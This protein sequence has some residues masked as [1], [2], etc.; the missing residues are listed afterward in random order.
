[1]GNSRERGMVRT[2]G[3]VFS[4]AAMVVVVGVVLGVLLVAISGLWAPLFA[5]PSG[6]MSPNLQVGD[7]V[8]V[9]EEGRFVPE[10]AYEDT[11]VVTY[12]RGRTV[13]YSTFNRPGDVIVF[14]PNGD[15]RVSLIHRA[16]FY[17]NE[18]EN[19]YETGR[20]VDERAVGRAENCAELTNCPAPHAG[21]ITKGD[22]LVRYDQVDNLTTPVRPEWVTGTGELRIP[23]LGFV[24]FL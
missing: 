6:S 13:G 1:M 16:M 12:R 10:P 7:V 4:G 5:V 19:W 17:V 22:S 21:F 20:R 23:W 14:H 15:D 24:R 9:M 11:G 8:V 18:S 2:L 3:A